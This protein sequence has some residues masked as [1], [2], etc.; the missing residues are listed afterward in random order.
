MYKRLWIDRSNSGVI[1]SK[2]ESE[3]LGHLNVRREMHAGQ[4]AAKL[5]TT[6]LG[7]AKGV[8]RKFIGHSTEVHPSGWKRSLPGNGEDDMVSAAWK[9]AGSPRVAQ[10]D[11]PGGK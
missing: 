9:H 11:K 1:Q 10:R 7:H 3:L 6:L 5:I 2:E 4:S 8:I